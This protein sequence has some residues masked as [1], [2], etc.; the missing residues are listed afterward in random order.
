MATLLIEYD[1]LTPGKDYADLLAAIKAYPWCH[2]LK[3]AW[4]V[5]AAL[6]AQQLAA[7]LRPHVDT[8]D[9]LVV[10]DLTGHTAYWYGLPDE[11]SSWIKAN[12]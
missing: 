9:R 12:W 10:F 8:N 11:I 3:S 6:S 2:H 7:A 5:I 1:L 4:L